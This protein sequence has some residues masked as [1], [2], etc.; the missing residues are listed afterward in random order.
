MASG[1]CG[2]VAEIIKL[3]PLRNVPVLSLIF[4]SVY[5][6]CGKI[7]GCGKGELLTGACL[8]NNAN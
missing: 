3:S 8:Y 1:V 5:K 2:I 7:R 6:K 4:Y